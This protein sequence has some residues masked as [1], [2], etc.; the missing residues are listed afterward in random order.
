MKNK[1]HALPETRSVHIGLV[2]IAML[3]LSG[4]A[5]QT[6]NLTNPESDPWEASNRRVYGFNTAVDNAILKPVAKGYDVIMPDAPQRGVRNFFRNLRWPVTFINLL[7]QGHVE[8]SLISTGRFLMNSTLGLF[9]FFDVATKAGIEDFDEDFGQ[10][11][12]VW[13]WKNSRFIMVPLIGPATIRDFSSEGVASYGIGS[14]LNPTR[15]MITE[16]NNYVPFIIDVISLR[17]SFL[18]YE[19]DIQSSTDPYAFV[20][21]AY[22]QSRRFNI[23]NGEPPAP[24]YDSLLEEH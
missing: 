24:D 20:R 21:D 11:L 15:Y 22:L 2:L 17:A 14:F 23:Y 10:T 1:M 19:K 3:M 5:S 8:D 7:L 4:C 16:H 6:A 12:A 13:G 18:P 9:G